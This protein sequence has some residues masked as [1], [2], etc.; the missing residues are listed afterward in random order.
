MCE[1]GIKSEFYEPR[2]F[3]LDSGKVKVITMHSS[4]GIEFPMVAIAG[5][6]ANEIPALYYSQDEEDKSEL[7][8]QEVEL[9]LHVTSKLMYSKIGNV[10]LERISKIIY[11]FKVPSKTVS[12]PAIRSGVING[13][14]EGKGKLTL[15]QFLNSYPN[16]VITIDVPA[17]LGI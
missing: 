1:A 15:I 5:A 9:T 10:I 14:I 6:N 2:D 16:K 11:P 12:I 3:Q 13:I 8:N 4:K 17:L 7:L